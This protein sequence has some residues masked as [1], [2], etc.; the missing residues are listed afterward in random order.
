MA[1][2]TDYIS[3]KMTQTWSF[4]AYQGTLLFLIM[5]SVNNHRCLICASAKQSTSKLCPSATKVIILCFTI[6]KWRYGQVV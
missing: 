3:D 5:V 4:S 1:K 6:G 2:N